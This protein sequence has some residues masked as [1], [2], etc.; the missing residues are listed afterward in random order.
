MTCY[1]NPAVTEPNGHIHFDNVS[2]V[3]L[4]VLSFSLLHRL[5]SVKPAVHGAT[6][7]FCPFK[8]VRLIPVCVGK[9]ECKSVTFPTFPPCIYYKHELSMKL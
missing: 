6:L 9:A 7:V 8:C 1:A 4:Q 5:H 2:V 3:S